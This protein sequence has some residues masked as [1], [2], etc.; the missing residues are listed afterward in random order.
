MIAPYYADEHVTIFHGDCSEIEAWLTAD[1]LVTDPPYGI[2]WKR[3]ANPAR[4]SKEHDGIRND[5][6]TSARD[7]A[8]RL[9]GG[10]A[11]AS[12][13]D[14][15]TLRRPPTFG[16][17][18]SGT[19]ATPKA[20]SVPR[21]DSVVTSSRCSSSTRGPFGLSSGHPSFAAIEARGTTSLPQLP[22]R[23][24]SRSI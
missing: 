14:R 18:S 20:S 12:C 21:R 19:R 16:R 11:L 23:T 15:S 6:D 3:S 10:V 8:L 22:T 13:L 2:G 7:D 17:C 5:E 24:R 4:L 9:W 1:V